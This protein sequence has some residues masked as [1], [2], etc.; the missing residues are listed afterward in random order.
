MNIFFFLV[1]FQTKAAE[2]RELILFKDFELKVSETFYESSKIFM[3]K[4]CKN[5]EVKCLNFVK[6]EIKKINNKKQSLLKG[7]PA[8][9][10]CSNLQGQSFIYYDKEHNEY[11]YCKI[12]GYEFSS[13]DIYY[14]LK[15]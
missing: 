13:W 7:N 4:V 8:S 6:S 9:E 11:D 2:T 1:I 5:E 3:N 10:L 12:K 15:K 14:N